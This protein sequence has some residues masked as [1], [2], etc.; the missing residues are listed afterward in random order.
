MMNEGARQGDSVPGAPKMSKPPSPWT[1]ASGLAAPCPWQGEDWRGHRSLQGVFRRPLSKKSKKAA[2]KTCPDGDTVR[3]WEQ[4]R[5]Q[6]RIL[7]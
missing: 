1:L 5:L 7:T 2:F 3:P 4:V 6:A